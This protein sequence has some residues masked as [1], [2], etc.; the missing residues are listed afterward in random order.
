MRIRILDLRE[1][2][3]PESDFYFFSDFQKFGVGGF[4]KQVFKKQRPNRSY[5]VWDLS[6]VVNGV[7]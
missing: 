6:L 1:L 7:K 5:V 4:I 2:K 3:N